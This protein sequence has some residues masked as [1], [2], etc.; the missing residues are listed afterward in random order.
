[1]EQGI[2]RGQIVTSPTTVK[3]IDTVI[4]NRKA[5]QLST[6]DSA[7]VESI[8]KEYVLIAEGYG[9]AVPTAASFTMVLNYLRSNFSWLE[10]GDLMTAFEM[11]VNEEYDKP[12]KIDA[13]GKSLN[14]Q[15]ISKVLRA[16]L[17]IRNEKVR[18]LKAAKLAAQEE[19]HKEAAIVQH[20]LKY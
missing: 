11:A 15:I 7:V 1:M 13:F 4:S 18:A 8:K 20:G 3:E 19:Q 6:N 12:I 10:P 9:Y 14:I 17:P 16:Y 5:R 2:T